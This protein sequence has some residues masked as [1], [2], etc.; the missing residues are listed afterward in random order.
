MSTTT[1]PDAQAAAP[2]SNTLATL[3]S[4]YYNALVAQLHMD[5]SSF[6]LAQGAISLGTDSSS[7]WNF[8]DSIPPV[9]LSRSWDSSGFNNLALAYGGVINNLIPQTSNA[10]Q[11]LLGDKYV[12]WQAYRSNASNIPSP[13][14]KL[15]N[16]QI[17]F[18]G[19]Q[20]TMF[21]TWGIAQLDAGQI[22][23]GVTLLGQTDV[24]SVANTMFN[25]AK[26]V[27]PFTATYGDVQNAHSIPGSISFN[28]SNYSSDTS[29]AW[30]QAEASGFFD[31]FSGGASGSWSQFNQQVESDG[32][33]VSISFQKV[34]TLPGLPLATLQNVDPELS[35]YVPWFD[36]EALHV[37]QQHNDNTVWKPSAPTWADTFG[38]DGNLLRLT[39]QLI[40]VDGVDITIETNF[41]VSSDDQTEINASY[42]AGFWP[43]F[44]T[45]GSGGWTHDHPTYSSSGATFHSSTVL[46]NP[47]VLGVTV[48]PI[49]T[50]FN[51]G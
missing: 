49:D 13:L 35:S 17:D 19:I 26:G 14:P 30:A 42:H 12:S 38:P 11:A 18:V 44:S 6:Q 27:Y 20:V 46:G 31:F 2:A 21:E 28:S 29:H 39:T 10:M 3:D 32:V 4:Q 45:S 24:V 40:V 41:A 7:I 34:I 25:A 33:T 15:A 23:S 9:S 5:P 37:A 8:F 43:F 22:Q 1:T 16:G 47:Q 48:S 50:V 36:G 51:N